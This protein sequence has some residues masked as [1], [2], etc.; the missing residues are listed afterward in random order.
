M[1][2]SNL[3]KVMAIL[4]ISIMLFGTSMMVYAAERSHVC[5]YSYVE[6]KDYGTQNAGTHTYTAGYQ[7]GQAITA[8]CTVTIHKYG[9]VYKCG[10]GSQYVDT[11]GVTIHSSC[12]Q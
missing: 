9:K 5:S 10:C 11:Y 8:S 12:G 3:R 2:K 4:V 1:R 6:L 7:N